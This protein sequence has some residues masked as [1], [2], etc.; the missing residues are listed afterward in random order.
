MSLLKMAVEKLPPSLRSSLENFSTAIFNS[1]VQLSFF[2]L[3]MFYMFVRLSLLKATNAENLHIVDIK[4]HFEPLVC[5]DLFSLNASSHLCFRFFFLL[6]TILVGE[7]AERPPEYLQNHLL[8]NVLKMKI[9]IF[10]FQLGGFAHLDPPPPP[11][12][13]PTWFQRFSC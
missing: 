1:D 4:I 3:F 7:Q 12:W 8:K 6:F 5:F 10:V 9:E 13:F 11:A 2:L